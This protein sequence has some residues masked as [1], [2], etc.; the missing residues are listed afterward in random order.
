MAIR[1]PLQ[2]KFDLG[3]F[4]D[5]LRLRDGR[6]LTLRFVEPKDADTLQSYFR[7]LSGPSRH[8]RL[9]GAASELP[10]QELAKSTHSGEHHIFAAIAELEDDSEDIVV[11]E[12]RYAFDPV[13]QV[14]EFGISTDDRFHG[15]GIATAILSNL[16]CRAAALGARQVFGET[17]RNNE[18]MIGLARKLGYRFVAAP[19]DWRQ[20]R[21]EKALSRD[22]GEIPCD[23]WRQAALAGAVPRAWTAN[24]N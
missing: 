13:Q 22:A 3:Q 6:R 17:L 8:N 5:R 21:F 4:T 12:V 24:A 9:M 14:V 10:P 7:K 11:A 2:A 23:Q 1:D 18:Q 16:E 19:H 15:R 20:V